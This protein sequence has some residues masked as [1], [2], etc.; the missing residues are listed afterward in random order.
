MPTFCRHNRFI[1]RCPICSRTLP[2]HGASEARPA[3]PSRK[4]SAAGS[5]TRGRSRGEGVRIRRE[6]RAEDDGFSSPLVPGLH[7]SADAGALAQEI[8]FSSARLDALAADPPGLYAEALAIAAADIERATWICFL[9]AYLSPLDDVEDPFAGIRR[10]LAS[11]PALSTLDARSGDL[12]EIP[13][14]PRSS[15]EPERGSSTLLAY[16]QWVQRSG[17]EG[18]QASAFAG[19][20][21]WSAERRFERLFERLA[22]PGFGRVG[23]YE[24]LLTLARLGLYELHPDSLHLAAGAGLAGDDQA[25]LAAKRVFG[26]ADQLLLN[27]RAGALA[28][29]ISVPVEA[30]DLA[31]A[32]WAAPRRASVGVSPELSDPDTQQR[33]RDALGL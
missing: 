13:L 17:G 29:A 16:R 5:R 7:A 8:A 23:R 31:L 15:H 6:G 33:V 2:D 25:T 1:E 26:I 9:I 32:N 10:A 3:R 12:A 4:A 18:S 30:L 24:L 11:H 27:R 21:A 20:P 22:L 19:D 14:G 28:Q